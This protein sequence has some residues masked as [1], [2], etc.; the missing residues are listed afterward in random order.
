MT[1]E[2]DFQAALDATPADWQ[3][4]LVF[5]DWLDD[6]GDARASGYRALAALRARPHST[7]SHWW[8]N[9]A[10]ADWSSHAGFNLLPEDWFEL[11][12]PSMESQSCHCDFESRRAAEDAA[13]AAF[14]RLSAQRQTEL[15]HDAEPNEARE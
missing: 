8:S 1:T 14:C 11:T 5:A 13:A 10:D 2:N 9:A 4:R 7:G 12:T 15:L 3:T 6:H